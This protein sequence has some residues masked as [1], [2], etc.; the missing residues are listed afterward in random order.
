[1]TTVIKKDGRKTPFYIGKILSNLDSVE[2]V[3]GVNLKNNKEN[4]IKNIQSEITQYKEIESTKILEIIENELAE[5]PLVLLAFE[6]L[7]RSEQKN[8]DQATCL[9]TQLERFNY[10][11]KNIMNE[12]GNK[13]SRT[14]MT[15]RDLLS[16]TVSK[17]LGLKEYPE[18]VQ[19]AHIKGVIH[20]HDLDRSPYQGI[21]NC[22]LPD[23]EYMLANGVQLGNAK[24]EPPKSIGTAVSILGILI[25]AISGEQYGG[26]SVH[27]LDQLLSPYGEMTLEKN[28]ALYREVITDEIKVEHFA[29]RKTSKDIYDAMQAFEYD[30]NTMTTT[31]AQTPFSTVSYGLGTSW[32]EREIQKQHLKVRYIGLGK[33]NLTAIFP[34][35]LYFVQEGINLKKSDPNYDIKKLAIKT[36]ASR[37]YPDVINVNELAKLKKAKK[38][39]TA[40][41]CRSFLH[42]WENKDGEEVYV[43]RNNLGVISINLPHLALQA[44]GNINAFFS[45]LDDTLELVRKG[46]HIKENSVMNTDIDLLPIMYTQ[47]GL[48]DPTGKK[49]VRDFYDGERYK[50]ASISIGYVGVHNAMIALTGNEDWQL[51]SEY[52]NLGIRMVKHLDDFATRIDDEFLAKP[53]VYA[54]P[55]ESLADRFAHIDRER[56][57]IIKGVNENIYYENS[58]HYPSNKA[59]DPVSKMK[60]EAQ[61]YNYTPGGFMFY[62]EQSNLS[63]NLMGMESLWDGFNYF[64]NIYAG[65]NTPND[66][67]NLCNWEGESRFIKDQG[68]TC[69]NCK[70]YDPE[71]MNVVRRLCGYLGHPNKRPVVGGKQVEMNARVKHY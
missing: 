62:I 26:V 37:I 39:I 43:G 23:F 30:I 12:N 7:K 11:D 29:K 41:G 35:I 67:C 2:R 3:F 56:F 1:M 51:V 48:G 50:Q 18:D 31:T 28:R 45:S 64:G 16:G 32:I 6:E 52:N 27:E 68:Y 24:V 49:K 38:P 44:R 42:Y 53:S 57:G 54:T 14:A 9:N 55:S 61:Y 4:I 34:K 63:E 17:V 60:F 69:P 21:P 5:D 13:D 40:M 25:S 47:G 20:L 70:N 36:S 33:N 46:L 10:K 19:R 8:I 59:I 66:R 58:F 22:S 71:T 65:V 15:Q